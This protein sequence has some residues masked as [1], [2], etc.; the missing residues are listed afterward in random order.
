MARK[1]R[2]EQVDSLDTWGIP[3][4]D[5]SLLVQLRKSKKKVKIK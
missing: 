4:D 5:A 1:W 3:Y 2:S